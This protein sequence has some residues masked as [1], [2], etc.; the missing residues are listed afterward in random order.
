MRGDRA[1]RYTHAMDRLEYNVRRRG[2][3]ARNQAGVWSR[4]VQETAG[5]LV[6]AGGRELAGLLTE[7]HGLRRRISEARRNGERRPELAARLRDVT[8]QIENLA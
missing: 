3:V 1:E 4:E 6:A 7:Q 8:A 2:T 5:R